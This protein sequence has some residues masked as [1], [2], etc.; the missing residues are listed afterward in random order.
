MSFLLVLI[1]F[2]LSTS[3]SSGRS[4]HIHEGEQL[5]HCR[6]HRHCHQHIVS[7]KATVASPSMGIQQI[8]K[9]GENVS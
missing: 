6:H 1:V 2:D 7:K 3:S 9:H 5:H 8:K 4:K